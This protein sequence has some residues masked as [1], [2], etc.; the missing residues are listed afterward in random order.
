MWF[1]QQISLKSRSR[2]CHLIQTE[3][4]QAIQ[5]ELSK[6]RI[7]L[8]HIFI[9]HTSASLTLNENCDQSVRADFDTIF[10][11]LVP[12]N[13]Y[14]EHSSEGP[15]DM[16]AHFKASMMGSSVTLPINNGKFVTGTWQ[17]LYLCEHRDHGGSRRIVVTIQ[18]E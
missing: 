16:P 4:E 2:G 5:K 9:L 10:D 14:Y 17:G 8:A 12:E 11:R 3:V 18:G 15:D 13:N 1:Q 7:G 6:I